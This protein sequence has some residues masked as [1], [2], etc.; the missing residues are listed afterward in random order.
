MSCEALLLLF[1]FEK[2]SFLVRKKRS[3]WK[4]RRKS[5]L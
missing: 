3:Q 1:A 4:M 5:I 2:D